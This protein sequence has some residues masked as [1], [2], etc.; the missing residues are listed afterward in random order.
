MY[1]HVRINPA[2]LLV[3]EGGG[4]DTSLSSKT[5]HYSIFVFGCITLRKLPKMKAN[6]KMILL[7]P[8]VSSNVGIVH[9][10]MSTFFIAC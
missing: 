4:T 7:M 5:N 3:K 9:F 2:Y 10:S 8:S 1:M 6:K